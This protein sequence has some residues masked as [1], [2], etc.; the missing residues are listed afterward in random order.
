MDSKNLVFVRGSFDYVEEPAARIGC[1]HGRHEASNMY[2]FRYMLPESSRSVNRFIAN[3][4]T[5]PRTAA[6][7]RG[8]PKTPTFQRPAAGASL[9]WLTPVRYVNRTVRMPSPTRPKQNACA[10]SSLNRALPATNARR[11][12]TR[13]H[14]SSSYYGLQVWQ[15]PL[16]GFAAPCRGKFRPDVAAR[17]RPQPTYLQRQLVWRAP[18][19]PLV[20]GFVTSYTFGDHQRP[21]PWNG[22]KPSY[23]RWCMVLQIHS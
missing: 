22:R 19:I 15:T 18:F 1:G 5:Q 4:G 20:Y 10:G 13:L 14:H 16:T 11:D 9:G 21:T 12:L 8:C 3:V 23:C 6:R 7:Q 2:V 17:T